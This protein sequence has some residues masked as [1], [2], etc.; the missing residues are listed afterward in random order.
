MHTVYCEK[1]THSLMLLDQGMPSS[2][3]AKF[4]GV[5]ENTV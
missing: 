2:D 1:R 4:T 3:E 5:S